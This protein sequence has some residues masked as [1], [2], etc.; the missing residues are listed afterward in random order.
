MTTVGRQKLGAREGF[1][2][3]DVKPQDL[4]VR[5]V[6]ASEIERKSNL[7]PSHR[8]LASLS[9]RYAIEALANISCRL[10]R[11]MSKL[12]AESNKFQHLSRYTAEV[13]EAL[14]RIRQDESLD[15]K[16]MRMA[17]DE[18]LSMAC[19]TFRTIIHFCRIY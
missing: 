11:E 19:I 15:L 9:V 3:P 2:V 10:K 8:R 14:R 13:I 6:M 5:T 4:S 7:P 16:D 18:V 17:L 12:S 1:S